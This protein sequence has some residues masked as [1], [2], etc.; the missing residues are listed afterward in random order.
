[1]ATRGGCFTVLTVSE[2]IGNI[3]VEVSYS[4]GAKAKRLVVISSMQKGLET[5]KIIQRK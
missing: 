2:E 3:N 1:M 5:A 4:I